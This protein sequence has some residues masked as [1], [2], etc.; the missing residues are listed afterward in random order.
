VAK[1]KIL[2]PIS[3]TAC[4][5]CAIYRGRHFYLCYSAA[6]KGSS[7][8]PDRIRQLKEAEKKK[9]SDK[10]FGIPEAIEVGSQC[11]N[12][13]EEYAIEKEFAALKRQIH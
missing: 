13:F 2:C 10:T 5:E 9:E 3:H 8:D 6:Y 1:H 12:N 11:I 7:F 4:T